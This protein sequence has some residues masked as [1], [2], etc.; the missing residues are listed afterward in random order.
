VRMWK[1]TS[2]T[3][4]SGP[5]RQEALAPPARL[6]LWPLTLRWEKTQAGEVTTL[7]PRR[8]KGA[9]QSG[10][11]WAVDQGGDGQCRASRLSQEDRVGLWG[12]A[13][14][15]HRGWVCAGTRT[16]GSPESA[17]GQ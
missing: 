16:H 3:F 7:P 8:P 17:P 14:C 15:G 6:L 1:V 13:G 4:R 11:S 10:R 2:S 9:W 5:C 12:L